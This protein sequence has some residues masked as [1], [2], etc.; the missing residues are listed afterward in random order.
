M[1]YLS[2]SGNQNK[3]GEIV[4]QFYQNSLIE[5]YGK[6][7]YPDVWPASMVS[8]T[9]ILHKQLTIQETK[10]RF[11]QALNIDETAQNALDWIK[12]NKQTAQFEKKLVNMQQRN[13]QL[14]ELDNVST[15]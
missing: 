9:D 8:L 2:V 12:E 7:G 4:R 14:E 5:N 13:K 15:L 6:K 10:E 3:R 1:M 11:V